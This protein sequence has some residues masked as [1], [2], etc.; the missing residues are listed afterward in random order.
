M[1]DTVVGSLWS[2]FLVSYVYRANSAF[3]GND[4]HR[5]GHWL[6]QSVTMYTV[7]KTNQYTGLQQHIV[8][9]FSSL[10]Q[11]RIGG[12][13]YYNMACFLDVHEKKT[14]GEYTGQVNQ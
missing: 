1:R 4:F 13:P 9:P 2:L 12:F 6:T 3:P 8:S 11:K 14:T 5:V 10:H 7:V